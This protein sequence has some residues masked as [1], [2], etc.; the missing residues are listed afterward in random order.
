M[1]NEW[2][3]PPMAHLLHNKIDGVGL[4]AINPQCLQPQK[5]EHLLKDE[6]GR[7]QYTRFI[8]RMLNRIRFEESNREEVDLL[9]DLIGD[10]DN[11]E[12]LRVAIPWIP[13]LKE[14]T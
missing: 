12:F 11:P 4:G 1:G 14:S 5:W 2:E 9:A 3:E 13:E 10:K 7:G 6:F 8:T